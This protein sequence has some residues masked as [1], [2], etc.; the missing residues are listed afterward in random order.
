MQII[1]PINLAVMHRD[2]S[3]LDTARMV[4]TVF[5]AEKLS[6][7]SFVNEQKMWRAL[8]S[9]FREQ[10]FDSGMPKTRGEVI[11]IGDFILGNKKNPAGGQ[12]ELKLTRV[13]HARSETLIDKKIVV[14]RNRVWTQRAGLWI[15]EEKIDTDQLTIPLSYQYAFGGKQIET[16]PVG[17]GAD[18]EKDSGLWPLPNI[19]Y[20]NSLQTHPGEKVRPAALGP[21]HYSSVMKTKF[22]GTINEESLLQGSRKLPKDFDMRFFNEVPDDQS[23]PGWFDGTERIF[24]KNLSPTQEV[25]ESK[26]T[27]FYGRCFVEKYEVPGT[28]RSRRL[29][30]VPMHFDTLWIIPEQDIAVSCFRAVI[31]GV[32]NGLEDS[33]RRAKT[34]L[35][36]FENRCDPKRDYEHYYEIFL[37]R[38]DPKE[39]YKHALNSAP[40]SPNG[41]SDPM[42][43]LKDDFGALPSSIRQ[44]NLAAFTSAKVAET[45]DGINSKK[46]A[47]L[48][49]DQFKEADKKAAEQA[50]S[51]ENTPKPEQLIRLESILDSVS[52]DLSKGKPIDLTQLDLS[53]LDKLDDYRVEVIDKEKERARLTLQ[54]K[55]RDLEPLE[56]STQKKEAI[57]TLENAIAEI[58]LPPMLPRPN[59][60]GIADNIEKLI[61]NFETEFSALPEEMKSGVKLPKIDIAS[62]K[63]KLSE[64]ETQFRDAYVLGAHMMLP[65]R[66]P[67]PGQEGD[68]RKQLLRKLENG[69]AISGGDYA[70]VDLTGLDLKGADLSNSYLECANLSHCNLRGADL[71]GAVLAGTNLESADLDG[72]DL[73]SANLGSANLFNTRL[74]NCDLTK[75]QF[76]RARIDHTDFSGSKFEDL[77]LINETIKDSLFLNCTFGVSNFIET[78]IIGCNFTGSEL[79]QSSFI[80]CVLEK[81]NLS[82]ADASRSTFLATKFDSYLCSDAKQVNTRYIGDC[83]FTDACFKGANLESSSFRGA[84]SVGIDFSSADI[85]N[86]DFTQC[87]FTASSFEHCTAKNTVFITSIL[88]GSSFEHANINAA[89]MTGADLVEV[90]FSDCNMFGVDLGGVTF[91][92]NF[93]AQANLD[94]TIIKE[95]QP[96]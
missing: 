45:R 23:F 83:E 89:M 92:K 1:K 20:P 61:K 6:N 77:T 34:L 25:I 86:S 75:T 46:D 37:K 39:A 95:W 24:L 5:I 56:E 9:V 87:N 26:V 36:A 73:G 96:S 12:A 59:I 91:G 16:N 30:E 8:S 22:I 93:F 76:G 82:N 84:K 90:N 63:D 81:V 49:V 66:S 31:D 33:E 72:A 10:T 52:P 35:F 79:I 41:M 3:L 51:E 44:E 18:A 27:D 70:F 62:I 32:G 78:S 50:F 71:S 94:R 47:V 2:I 14:R 58:D 74:I 64:T 68:I 55:I 80:S 53:Q 7:K 69:E 88:K 28:V 42:E 40:L 43:E 65:A 67:H 4:A 48:G 57:A 17:K 21:I 13:G 15:A 11:V 85:S 19:E 54:E 38:T 60:A 29:E